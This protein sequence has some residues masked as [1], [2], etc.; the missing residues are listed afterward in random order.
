MTRHPAY[1]SQPRSDLVDFMLTESPSRGTVLDVGCGEGAMGAAL[2][3][4][5]FGP[6]SG[7]EPVESAASVAAA[8]LTDVVV[9]TF[10]NARI[11]ERAPYDYV[12][13]ADSL[14]HLTD[15]WSALR[16]ARM[17]LAPS[18]R[19]VLSVPNVSHHSVSLQLLRGKWDYRDWGLLDRTHLRFFTPS[20]LDLIVRE[21]GFTVTSVR[22]LTQPTRRR[23][24]LLGRALRQFAPYMLATH[25]FLMARPLQTK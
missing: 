5:G 3:A 17:L 10:P 2:L 15:P 20:S 22:Y 11:R 9:G 25:T 24:R 14:E 1:Y 21:T 8:K 19:L 13:F 16:E 6:V 7:V 12:V 18:G 23:Y 4:G